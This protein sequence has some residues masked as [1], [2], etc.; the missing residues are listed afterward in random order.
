[1]YLVLVLLTK[2]ATPEMVGLYGISQAVALPIST[3]LTLRLRT[4]QVTDVANQ[5][6]FGEYLAV[7]ILTAA[8][9]VVIVTIVALVKEP[10]STAIIIIMLGVGY[11]GAN[12]QEVFLAVMQKAERMQY[13]ALDRILGGVLSLA[14]FALLFVMTQ[15]LVWALMGFAAAHFLVLFLY[16]I[17]V[18]RSLRLRQADSMGGGPHPRWNP[19]RLVQ[20]A[21]SAAPL[22]L[23]AWFGSLL[24]SIPRLVLDQYRTR[25]E[26]GYFVAISSLLVLGNV[27]TVAMGQAVSPRLAK[28]FHQNIRH[29]LTLLFKFSV[30]SILI[31][32]LGFAGSL[33]FGRPI[34]TLLFTPEY[35]EYGRLFAVIM[36]AG[37]CLFLFS[38]TNT[39]LN[40]ARAF[41]VQI[42]IFS[43][44]V[45]ASFFGSLYAIPRYGLI[46]AAYAI[47]FA[48]AVGLVVSL[49]ALWNIVVR[50][51]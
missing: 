14:G 3:L 37:L 25:A 26:V 4:V 2:M 13:M 12:L 15:R 24:T 48:Y 10:P 30:V 9:T 19:Q 21:W 44:A 45:V 29:Y 43:M 40:A 50:R 20:L 31:G 8:S 39:A 28:Y 5:F 6:V 41:W 11:A 33:L 47:I 38:C 1:M 36:A 51:G 18:T 17:P 23:V 22:A 7:T 49:C 46:G 32:I 42:P 34:L 16:D 27:I 35:A